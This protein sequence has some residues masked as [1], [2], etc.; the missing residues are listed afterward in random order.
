MYKNDYETGHTVI[1]RNGNVTEALRRFKQKMKEVNLYIDL[2]KNQ[3]Y[4]KPSQ[5]R[6]EAKKR[7]I[8][9]AKAK[10]KK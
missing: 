7:G 5:L 9:R 2:K 4:V 1:V 3:Q 10:N 8:Q 6:K